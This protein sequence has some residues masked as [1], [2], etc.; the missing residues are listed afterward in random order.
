MKT[1]TETKGASRDL[2][3]LS[4]EKLLGFYRVMVTARRIDDR[5]IKMKAQNKIF[6]QISGAGHEAVQVALAEYL[7]PAYDWFYL[8]YR[9]RALALCL[10]QTPLDH[11][12]Q[13]VGAEDDPASGGRGMPAHFGDVRYNIPSVS[14]PTGSQFLAAVGSAEAGYR[15]SLLPEMR[16]VV[17]KF[18]EDEIIL[19]TAGDGAT[20]EGEFWE[21]LNTACTLRLPSSI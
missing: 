11:F 20:S 10:G 2:R 17:G 16:N 19:V 7:M 13:A 8:Y 18:A 9:D 14:S 4:P 1:Q 15:M 6:F 21:S 3:G 12:L 5:E